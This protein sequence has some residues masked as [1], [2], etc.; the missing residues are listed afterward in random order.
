MIYKNL[1]ILK[2]HREEIDFSQI[3]TRR[4]ELAAQ[5]IKIEH[6]N[7][8]KK[9][10]TELPEK[11]TELFEINDGEIFIGKR[12]EL[13]AEEHEL[14]RKAIY[15][16]I[17][18]RKGPYSLFDHKIDSE[19]VLK[20]KWERVSPLL[21][22]PAG[23]RIIDIGGNNGY[24]S[25]RLLKYDPK[26]ILNID[27][28][29]RCYFQFHLFQ[30]FLQEQRIQF[31][32]LGVE[33]CPLMPNFFHTALFMGIIY[34]CRAPI[35]ALQQVL[36]CLK[37]GG[38]MIFESITVPG[39]GPTSLSV[40][41][42]YAKMRNCWFIPTKDCMVSWAHKAGFKEIEIVSDIAHPASEQRKTELMP[43]E[44]FEDFLDPEDATKTAEGYP[45]PRRT[46][47][48]ARKKR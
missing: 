33:D 10:L 20:S 46:I 27:P 8:L 6:W 28:S 35:D 17:P 30:R 43:Y 23:R 31:E 11:K 26:F 7:S 13:N 5:F 40:P 39:D 41:D 36:S 1:D 9:I 32:L 21:D 24:F 47:V 18:W 34:H 45:A 4:N 29:G 37:P 12:D 42:R 44:S 14:L 3:E 22:N 48:V 2:L 19:W 25:F 15:A 38:Q 16:L